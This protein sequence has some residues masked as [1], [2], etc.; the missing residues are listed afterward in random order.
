MRLTGART[1]VTGGSAGIGLATARL[2]AARGCGVTVL[3]SDPERVADAAAAVTGTGVVCDLADPTAVSDLAERLA[4]EPA[5]DLVMHNA[6]IGLRGPA[7]DLPAPDL[8]R[9]LAVNVRA[10]ISLTA[11]LLPAMLGRGHGRLVYVG[12]IAGTVGAAGETAYAASKAALQ[13]Y[14]DGLRAELAGTG[15]GVTLLLPGVVATAFFD[16]RGVPYHRPR[17]RPVPA[18]RVARGLV[19]G[20]ERDRDLVVVP[21]WLRG[22]IALH[23]VAPQTFARLAGRWGR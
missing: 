13:G 5:F 9:L 21:G 3:G 11:A 6:G 15:V 4:G 8:D 7:A 1:L 23:G 19:R 12:S 2:L 18:Q 10:P 16:R 22:P 17:P 14:A 20:I